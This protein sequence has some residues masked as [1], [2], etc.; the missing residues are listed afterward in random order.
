[1][2]L[3]VLFGNGTVLTTPAYYVGASTL[4]FG[5]LDRDGDIDVFDFRNALVPNFGT[6]TA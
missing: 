2:Q 5:D 1:M 4:P 6:S 3:D